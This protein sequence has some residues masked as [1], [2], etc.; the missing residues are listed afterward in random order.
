MAKTIVKYLGPVGSYTYEIANEFIRQHQLTDVILEPFESIT[1]IVVSAENTLGNQ[2]YL[3]IPLENSTSGDVYET[4]NDLYIYNFCVI[5]TLRL[6]INHVLIGLEHAELSDIKTLYS[7]TQALMQVSNYTK[8]HQLQT[9][10]YFSTTDAVR[11]ISEKGDTSL[12]AIASASSASYYPTTKILAKD[13]SNNTNNFT[14]FLVLTPNKSDER[15]NFHIEASNSKE[16]QLFL[17]F[18][19]VEDKSGQLS[20]FL[21]VLSK[22]HINLNNIKSRPIEGKIFEYFFVVEA[23]IPDGMSIAEHTALMEELKFFTKKV[24]YNIY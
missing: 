7:H 21:N 14:R 3:V 4:Y 17:L 16:Q 19:L 22:Y 13:V 9:V 20:H 15:Y 24:T 5:S 10:P 11:Y 2:E 18:E 8:Q 23:T 12:G 6:E 1:E